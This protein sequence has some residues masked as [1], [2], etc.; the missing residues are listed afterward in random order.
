VFILGKL[1][2]FAYS[3]R[4]IAVF[5]V[6]RVYLS[7]NTLLD[8]GEDRNISKENERTKGRNVVTSIHVIVYVGI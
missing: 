8:G 1:S 5:F 2:Y 7:V 3:W 6:L 4:H